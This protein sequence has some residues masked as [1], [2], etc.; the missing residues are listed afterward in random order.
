MIYWWSRVV[1][2]RLPIETAAGAK[3]SSYGKVTDSDAKFDQ[4]IHHRFASRLQWIR[5]IWNGESATVHHLRRSAA[6]GRASSLWET[7]R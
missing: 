3:Q 2:K 7:D 5:L 1:L 4:P 6:W